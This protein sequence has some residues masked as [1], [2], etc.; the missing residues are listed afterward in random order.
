MGSLKLITKIK[1]QLMAYGI[2]FS[3][4]SQEIV[5]SEEMNSLFCLFISTEN[6]AYRENGHFLCYRVSL[7]TILFNYFCL[8]LFLYLYILVHIFFF[9]SF[10]FF[11]SFPIIRIVVSHVFLVRHS[12]MIAYFSFGIY[13]IREVLAWSFYSVFEFHPTTKSKNICLIINAF[14]SFH[15]KKNSSDFE[16][17]H[18]ISTQRNFLQYQSILFLNK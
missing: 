9:I 8:S 12:E 18:I 10:L 15:F 2:Y 3:A 5:N 16:Y 6:P 13:I 7:I 1:I 14:Q 11:L 17:F 4:K